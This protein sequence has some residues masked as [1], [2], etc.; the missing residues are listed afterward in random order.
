MFIKR[1][2]LIIFFLFSFINSIL[3][4]ELKEKSSIIVELNSPRTTEIIP[5]L[6][7][8]DNIYYFCDN[9]YDFYYTN[10]NNNDNNIYYIV[11]KE[12]IKDSIQ[13]YNAIKVNSID[14][15]VELL[16]LEDNKKVFIVPLR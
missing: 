2:L 13:K 10:I 4:Q 6:I 7:E 8:R 15:K 5:L 3:G 9:F 16:G 11:E 14:L 1:I 12:S